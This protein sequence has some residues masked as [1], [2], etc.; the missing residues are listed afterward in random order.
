MGGAQT[1][2]KD[3]TTSDIWLQ[4]AA[5]WYVPLIVILGATALAL[6]D[7]MA[8]ITISTSETLQT[9]FW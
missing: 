1:Y 9:V 5:L 2:T 3:G 8:L 4:N 6:P 7:R